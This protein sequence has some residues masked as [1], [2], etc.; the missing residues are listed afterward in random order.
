MLGGFVK[1]PRGLFDQPPF[2]RPG[3]DSFDRNSAFVWL[4]EH[5]AWTS[6]T[7]NAGGRSVDLERGQLCHSLRRL[8]ATWCWSETSVRR[9]LDALRIRRL[10]DA[11]SV[12][13][14]T[15]V[16]ICNF[17]DFCGRGRT[18]DAPSVAGPSQDRRKVKEEKNPSANAEGT[19]TRTR[20]A[21]LPDGFEVPPDWITEAHW[22]REKAS[23]PPVDLATEAI[24]FCNHFISKS[25]RDA[26]KNDW[27]RAWQNWALNARGESFGNHRAGGQAPSTNLFGGADLAATKWERRQRDRGLGGPVA[28]PLLDGG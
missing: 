18:A 3:R 17:D 16:T 26:A 27:R 10:A 8:A 25:G 7:I 20:G 5:A 6:T 13:G 12:A 2:N 23:K 28:Q 15:V 22:A 14:Q 11:A 24:K 19:T 21:R 4:V 9:F 1:I